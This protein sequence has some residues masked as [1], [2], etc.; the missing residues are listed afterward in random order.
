[1]LVAVIVPQVVADA[2]VVASYPSQVGS[3]GRQVK[4]LLQSKQ[5]T[6]ASE[7]PRVGPG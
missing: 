6:L 3:R 7:T 2:F 4:G 1:M 5:L